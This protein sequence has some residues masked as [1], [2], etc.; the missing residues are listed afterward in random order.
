[1]SIVKTAKMLHIIS[2]TIFKPLIKIIIYS[3]CVFV[4]KLFKRNDP[5]PLYK[6]KN[7]GS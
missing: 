4:K 6:Y 3:S 1:M 5:L 2:D 7:A